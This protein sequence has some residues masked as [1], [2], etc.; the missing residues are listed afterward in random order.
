LQVIGYNTPH[1]DKHDVMYNFI[2]HAYST[3][4]GENLMTN[5]TN[6]QE[7]Q[8]IVNNLLKSVINFSNEQKQLQNANP[9][10][11]VQH[12][13]N[14]YV[15]TLNEFNSKEHKKQSKGKPKVIVF[16]QLHKVIDNIPQYRVK[17]MLYNFVKNL[18][19]EYYFSNG[20]DPFNVSSLMVCQE[21]YGYDKMRNPMYG[22]LVI[23]SKLQFTGAVSDLLNI[24]EQQKLFKELYGA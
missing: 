5:S 3:K 14:V 9:M 22:D 13:Q 4:Q 8:L 18:N 21:F 7:I 11:V 20:F 6:K 23:V 24:E 2:H 19:I 1:Q 16:N 10:S 15:Q 17:S 12:K